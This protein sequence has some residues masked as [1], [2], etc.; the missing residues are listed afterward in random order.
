MR[1]V[2]WW[3][4]KWDSSWPWPGY[5]CLSLK[6][7]SLHKAEQCTWHVCHACRNVQNDKSFTRSVC[8]GGGA[9][10]VWRGCS[11][12]TLTC[13]GMVVPPP[14]VSTSQAAPRSPPQQDWW[15]SDCKQAISVSQEIIHYAD[16]W[17]E[18]D[19]PFPLLR[20]SLTW[21]APASQGL[22]GEMVRDLGQFLL[23]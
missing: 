16:R 4:K 18:F 10:G 12:A 5:I 6:N 3:E 9:V 11:T 19:E 15:C 17:E 1:I 7:W 23:S 14:P 13:L 20:L 22:L 2:A 8:V 21:M